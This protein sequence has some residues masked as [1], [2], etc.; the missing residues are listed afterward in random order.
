MSPPPVRYRGVTR[1]RLTAALGRAE[2]SLARVEA[3][4]RA[5]LAAH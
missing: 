3:E 4:R 5:L 2:A 1:A